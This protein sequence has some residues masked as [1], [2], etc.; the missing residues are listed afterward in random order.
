M[1]ENYVTKQGKSKLSN[2][3]MA[4]LMYA[5][6]IC[7]VKLI[8]SYGVGIYNLTKSQNSRHSYEFMISIDKDTISKFE[9]M[10]GIKLKDPMIVYLA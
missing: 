4:S 5:I 9:E 2:T 7:K 3:H 10:T 1:Y 8:S 6:V